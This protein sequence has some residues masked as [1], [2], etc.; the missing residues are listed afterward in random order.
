VIVVQERTPDHTTPSFILSLR[1]I[2]ELIC[3]DLRIE[4]RAK[5][6]FLSSVLFAQLLC[7]IAAVL[8]E[9]R[10]ANG[11]G[12]MFLCLAFSGIIAVQRNVLKDR[13]KT[14]TWRLSGLPLGVFFVAKMVTSFIFALTVILSVLPPLTAFF[15]YQFPSPWYYGLAIV[16]LVTIG[17][18]SLAVVFSA[19]LMR[20][21]RG[22]ALIFLAVYPL[23]FPLF[24]A[25]ANGVLALTN[26]IPQLPLASIWIR[27]LLA[28]D[29]VI[30]TLSYWI[31]GKLL[32]E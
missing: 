2:Y 27:I 22:S 17:F 4:W 10:A 19:G 29:V 1:V 12:V 14:D 23:S 3:R 7:I 9:Q 26:E 32:E 21:T 11:S 31:F 6:T 25:G 28:A 13:G 16:A 18:C 15:H 24:L 5:E 30:L 20:S 8:I